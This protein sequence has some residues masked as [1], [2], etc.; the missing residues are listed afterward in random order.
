MIRVFPESLSNITNRNQ[1]ERIYL[2]TSKP[3]MYFTTALEDLILE[4]DHF[5]VMPAVVS[6]CLSSK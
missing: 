2:E 6:R 1:L 4:H 5:S 3:T